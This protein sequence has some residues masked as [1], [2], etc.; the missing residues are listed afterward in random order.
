MDGRRDRRLEDWVELAAAAVERARRSLGD[1]EVSRRVDAGVTDDEY[2]T[3]VRVLRAM[4]R[5]LQSTGPDLTALDGRLQAH[6]AQHPHV[7]ESPEDASPS[8][9][10]SEAVAEDQAEVEQN[11]EPTL[12]DLPPHER[13]AVRPAELAMRLARLRNP[14]LPHPRRQPGKR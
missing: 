1:E 5:D 13:G 9:G 2:E 12:D 10:R 14:I 7:P 6:V 4:G 3:V 8:D 11:P